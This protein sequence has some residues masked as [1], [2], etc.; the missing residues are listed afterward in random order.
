MIYFDYAA[1]T[2][3]SKK[4]IEAITSSLEAFPGNPSSV[5]PD[6]FKARKE[7]NRIKDEMATLLNAPKSSL[8]FTSSG[9]ESNNLIIQGRY[10]KRPQH[11]FITTRTEHHSV[12]KTFEHLEQL[13]ADVVYLPVS[14]EGYVSSKDLEN[15][16]KVPTA[17]VSILYANNETGVVQ[18]IPELAQ[19]SHQAEALFHTDMVQVWLHKPINFKTLDV[20]FATLSAH[21]F[22]GPKGIGLAYV[23]DST[24][25]HPHTFGGRQEHQLRAGTEN[26]AYMAGLLTALQETDSKRDLWKTNTDALSQYLLDGLNAEKI[27]FDLNGPELSQARFKAILNLSF[28]GIDAH[29]FRFF[30]NQNDVYLSLGSACDS[31]S[32]LPSHVL[33]AMIKD[34]KRIKSAV[35]ISLGPETQ[36]KDI[37]TFIQ[38]I[39]EYLK[40]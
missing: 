36:K 26:V 39:K 15:A 10:F 28:H 1:T 14:L 30:L 2:A 21:K 6:G 23:K 31:Q 35:R 11:R 34:E 5:H 37:D 33:S 38:L 16:L 40:K 22:M 19:I 24:S 9:T 8:L 3:P 12:L 27:S 29:E 7:L 17:L 25:I 32:E 4:V 20:D 13:G 18:N